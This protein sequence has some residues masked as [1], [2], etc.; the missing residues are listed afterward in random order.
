[1]ERF[2]VSP[3]F[4][5]L[6]RGILDKDS[7]HDFT[8]FRL[9]NFVTILKPSALLLSFTGPALFY[10]AKRCSTPNIAC[11]NT[12]L[13]TNDIGQLIVTNTMR[14]AAVEPVQG[15]FACAQGYA[16]AVLAVKKGQIV[17]CLNLV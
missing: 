12:L 4:A 2:R 16:F 7:G 3:R 13:N 11:L 10:P 5:S 9:S 14:K 15:K 17:S 1:M 8:G 6:E